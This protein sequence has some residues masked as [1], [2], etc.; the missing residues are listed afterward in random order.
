MKNQ[1]IPISQ[2]AINNE[3]IPTVNARDLHNFLELGKD[4]SNWVKNQIARA[5]L[6]ENRD[7]I[8][9]AEKGELSKTG[10]TR[11]EYYLTIEASKHISMMSGADK[12]FE[13]R[14]YFLECE[15]QAKQ[16]A[17]Q[18]QIPQTLP[19]ALRLAANLAEKNETLEALNSQLA[20]KAEIAERITA[21]DG[22]MTLT[23][24]AKILQVRPR[25]FSRWLQAHRWIYKRPGSRSLIPYQEKIQAGYLEL[26]CVLIPSAEDQERTFSQTIFLPKGITKLAEIF[27]Q[28]KAVAA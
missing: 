22:Y 6:V 25:E 10:Q 28:G 1:L 27:G 17:P 7:Y 13:V 16:I 20:P 12:G 24:T 23:D 18:F 4:F 8:K 19:E 14:D 2:S 26:K 5:R 21:A 9:V 15:R 3:L 11:L